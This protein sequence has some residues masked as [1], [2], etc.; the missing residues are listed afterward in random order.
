MLDEVPVAFLVIEGQT[1]ET[2]AAIHARCLERL[3]D[4]KR[5]RS[6]HV[7]DELPKGLLDKVL[8]REL[9]EL[10]VRLAVPVNAPAERRR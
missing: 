9:R 7:V 1:D 2:L 3:A 4:F 6:L 10:A 5:P 8:K